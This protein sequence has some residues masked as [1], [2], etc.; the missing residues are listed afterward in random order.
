MRNTLANEIY[1]YAAKNK[2]FFLISGDAGLGVWDEY[3]KELPNQFINPGINEALC[4]GM[5]AGMAL[6]GKKV[7][8]YNIAPFVIMRPFE[9]V[10]ND[11]C[12]QELPVILVGTGAGITYAPSG[13]THYSVE[14]IALALSLPNLDIYSPASP[15]EAK[16]AFENA[17]KSKNPSY[18]RIEK[19]G[20]VEIH[21]N[22][23]DITDLNFIQIGGEDL[24]IAH[25]SIVNECL[26]I[27]NVSVATAP[28]INS[29]NKNIIDQISKFRNIFVVEEHFK[30]GGLAT[31]L[32]SKTDKKIHS[33]GLK[34]HYIHDIGDRKFLRKLYGLDKSAI[35]KQIKENI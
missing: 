1:K 28:F 17:L 25:G 21:K 20:E 2:D 23:I 34:N 4:V 29:A 22:N 10:R 15:L 3:Q 16:L 24:V 11:I 30:F 27:S 9:Q 32:Q 31:F 26:G 5:A 8:Y 13:M 19:S 35:E 6:S 14:D 7:V 33:I 18:I 12:Y